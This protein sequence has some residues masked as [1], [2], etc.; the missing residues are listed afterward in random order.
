LNN[1]FISHNAADAPIARQ[2][3]D[4]LQ[5]VGATI[6]PRGHTPKLQ[7]CALLLLVM[8]PQAMQDAKVENE[9]TLFLEQGRPLVPLYWREC[10]PHYRLARLQYVDFRTNCVSY[11]QAFNHLLHELGKD[12]YMDIWLAPPRPTAEVPQHTVKELIRDQSAKTQKKPFLRRR[13]QTSLLAVLSA[14]SVLFVVVSLMVQQ[15]IDAS[16]QQLAA[17]VAPP[18]NV[19]QEPEI[20]LHYDDDLLTITNL[21][22]VAMD[23]SSLRFASPNMTF[24]AVERLRGL[25][26][27]GGEDSIYGLPPGSCFQLH[28]RLQNTGVFFR[29]N[30]CQQR[31]G[32][33]LVAPE[34][35]F[36][37]ETFD[38]FYGDRRITSCQPYEDSCE[39][40]LTD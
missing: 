33:V 34:E 9:W 31:E 29:E 25:S 40:R 3:A 22:E 16:D 23:I 13:K 27:R 35:R 15:M 17:A 28:T 6:V 10:D 20:G 7:D 11:D 30:G 18:T 4:D 1:I 19:P 37:G 5:S 8:S 2:L 12:R 32:W 38:I 24:N 21:T 14:V 39:F 36:W 26:S